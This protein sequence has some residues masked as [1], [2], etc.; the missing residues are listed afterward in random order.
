LSSD[1]VSLLLI[2]RQVYM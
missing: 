2:H 1:T